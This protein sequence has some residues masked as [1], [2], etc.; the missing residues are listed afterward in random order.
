MIVDQARA[1]G[2]Y[3]VPPDDLAERAAGALQFSPLMPGSES[4]E[5]QAD[6]SLAGM[7]M[8]APPGT[9]ERRYAIAHA[10]RA[11]ARAPPD[12]ARAQGQGRLA[13]RQ[14]AEGFR[15]RGHRDRPPPSP[16]LRGRPARRARARR[17]IAEG[18]PRFLADLGLWSQPGD[19]QLEPRR[20]GQRVA[21]R[22][23]CPPC[24]AGAPISAAASAYLS[25]PIL[26]SPEVQHL[27]LIDIDRRAVE[28]PAQSAG[29][30]RRDP[31]GRRPRL[32]TRAWPRL[33]FVVMNPPFHDGGSEDR[34]LGVR[35]HPPAAE[36]LHRAEPA[37]SSPTG[38][39]PT[40]PR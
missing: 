9:I 29:P 11:L 6:G 23:I 39:C 15:L 5:A 8:L 38:T 30:P 34:A 10:L 19:L 27:T 13:P 26:A 25:G 14:G 4:L 32:R 35:L 12:R 22:S 17:G 20:S 18:A 7:T 3:G 2:I 16:D 33:D 24:R 40:R 21:R 28:A 1:E 31:L 37:G 36:M